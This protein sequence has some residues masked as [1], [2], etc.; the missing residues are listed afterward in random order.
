MAYDINKVSADLESVLHGT[1]LNSITNLFGLYDRAGRKLI[2]DVDPQETKRIVET[3]GPIFNTI[4]D[5]PCPADLKGNKI[6]DIR[7]QVNRQ[8]WDI[9]LQSYNQTFDTTKQ[10]SGQDQFTI[11][12]NTGIKTVRID[13]PNLPAPV[14][15]NSASTL[16]GNG[17][18]VV[19]GGASNLRID[20]QNFVV[21]GGSLEIDLLAGQ[22]SGYLQNSTMYPIN[23]QVALNQATQF[24][25]SY[26]PSATAVS[27]VEFRFGSD[28]ANYYVLSKSTTQQNTVFQNG[29]NLLAFP[30]VNMTVVGAPNPASITYLR[31]TWA[32]NGTLQTGVRLNNILSVLGNILEIEYYSKYLYRDAITG[33]FQET[34]TDNTNL[35]NLDTE[36]YNLYFNL[37]AYYAVQ[38]Q[39]GLNA[40]FYDGPFFLNQYNEGLTRYKAMYK[41]ELQKPTQR[42]Y[43]MPQASYSQTIGSSWI[44]RW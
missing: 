4:W 43:S 29:W 14:V 9:W 5:Y 16:T 40:S 28:S 6:I 31:V 3:S 10:T 33:A 21:D 42:Y 44:I 11:N 35:I 34:V 8:L 41:S 26:L 39:Q 1:T 32:Y 36:S 7:P 17:T 19:G 24:L 12:F 27:A 18:W 15:I 22:F 2:E 25:Y 30:W 37:V 23:L 13:A 38:Q 20:N